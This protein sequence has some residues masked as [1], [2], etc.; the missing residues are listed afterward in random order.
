VFAND[1]FSLAR[2]V[3]MGNNETTDQRPT[4]PAQ[5]EQIRTIFI[6]VFSHCL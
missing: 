5:N 3:G 6:I 2:I 1:I 4:R